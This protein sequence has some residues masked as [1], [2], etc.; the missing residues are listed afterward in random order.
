MTTNGSIPTTT[1]VE[2]MDRAVWALE[3]V[4]PEDVH[5]NVRR[6]WLN[7]RPLAVK[8][9]IAPV[10]GEEYVGVRADWAVYQNEIYEIARR[11]VDLLPAHWRGWEPSNELMA[12]LDG[13]RHFIS[14]EHVVLA[15]IRA[16]ARE[17][18]S[19]SQPS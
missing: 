3:L 1:P 7:V 15:D 12:N 13:L 8:A 16:D 14:E 4:V 18:P 2:E 6:K 11:I 19:D 17:P 5:T 9:V 10:P